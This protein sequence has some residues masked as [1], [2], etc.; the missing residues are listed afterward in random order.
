MKKKASKNKIAGR[1]LRWLLGQFKP[2]RW[3]IAGLLLLQCAVSAL[4]VVSVVVNKYLV[5]MATANSSLGLGIGIMLGATV[6]TVA[7]NLFVQMWMITFNEKCCFS[8][9]TAVYKKLLHS[10]MQE[11]RRFHSEDVLTR[12][13]SDVEKVT[14][15]ILHI[16]ING[17]GTLLKLIS[18]FALLYYYDAGLALAVLL[19]APIGVGTFLLLS[20]KMRR[21]QEN[22]QKSEGAYRVFLQENLRNMEVVKAFSG[23]DV[24]EEKLLQLRDERL[25]WTVKMRRLQTVTRAVVNVTFTLGTT[26]AFLVGVLRIADNSITFGTMTAFLSLVGQ[27]QTPVL[28]LGEM[29]RRLITVFASIPRIMELEGLEKDETDTASMVAGSVEIRGENISFAYDRED[30]LHDFSFAV[31]SGQVVAVTGHSGAGKTTLIKLLLGFTTPDAGKLTLQTESGEVPVSAATRKYFSYVPQ[32]NTLFHGTIRENLQMADPEA[33]DERLWAALETA[34]AKEFV[35][36]LPEGLD[37]MLGEQSSG[38]SEGQAQRIAIARAMLR[39]APVVIF[40]EATSA[41]DEETETKI[42]ENIRKKPD[43]T[44]YIII[45]HRQKALEY[46]TDNIVIE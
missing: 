28:S 27:V 16:L 19:I 37:T 1:D 31:A 34:C 30:I 10:R 24:S 15:G 46:C 2:H 9:R 13:T 26:L 41:L 8:I 18:A 33:E 12:L 11:L 3:Q 45:T 36:N 17:I 20:G 6:L 7:I 23:E 44:A 35:E 43:G 22:F 4:G 38:I 39:K 29:A 14:S 40:D 25:Y 5:D 32:G 42:L 21:I